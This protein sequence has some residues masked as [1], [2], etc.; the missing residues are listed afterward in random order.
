MIADLQRALRN[1]ASFLRGN[2]RW[3]AGGLLLTLSSGVGQTYFIALFSGQI[4]AEYGFGHGDFGLVYMLATLASA[5]TL[6]WLGRIVDH[7][8]TRWVAIGSIALLAA[9]A[10]LMAVSRHILTLVLALYALRLFGQGMLSHVA[11][12]A[13]GRWFVA[14]RGRA[15]ALTA[16]GYQVGEGVFPILVVSLLAIFDWRLV[17]VGAAAILLLVTLPSA[18]GLLGVAR[19]PSA[20]DVELADSSRQ[21][22]RSEVA[23]DPL[24]WIVILGVLAPSFI[25]TSVFFHQVHIAEIKAWSPSV[26]ARAFSVMAVCTV[27]IG[28]ISGR[29]IDAIGSV[30]MLP[31]FL[32]PLG[33]ACLLLA[34]VDDPKGAVGFM[35]MLGVSYGMSSSIFGAVWPEIYGT[36]HLGAVRSLVFAG[37]VFSSALGPGLTGWLIDNDLGFERQLVVMGLYCGVISVVMLVVSRRLRARAADWLSHNQPLRIA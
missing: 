27:V 21:W 5:A 24:F 9:A 36:R 22:T 23:R 31:Y 26:V 33:L 15:V 6:M 1:Y 20:R 7:R 19:T 3:L 37:M 8:S 10:V 11:M 35:A 12:T 18:F 28:L 17:W 30:R 2:A 34:G 4:R 13:M 25:G 29:V 14:E 32:L 16:T